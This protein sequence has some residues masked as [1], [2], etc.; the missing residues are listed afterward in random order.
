[1]FKEF[2]R[3]EIKNL[4]WFWLWDLLCEEEKKILGSECKG[5]FVFRFIEEKGSHRCLRN[6]KFY[7]KNLVDL[8]AHLINRAKC[9]KKHLCMVVIW[10]QLSTSWNRICWIFF[11]FFLESYGFS[12]GTSMTISITYGSMHELT[13]SFGCG[14][15]Y[16]SCC[17]WKGVNCSA[18]YRWVYGSES[19]ACLKK[20]KILFTERTFFVLKL[21]SARKILLTDAMLCILTLAFKLLILFG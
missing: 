18:L 17:I 6:Q 15:L 2:K 8:Q 14:K 19:F 7:N 3:K 12:C 4:G 20:S 16:F 5:I 21:S 13:F 10:F 11:F 1:M 9:K